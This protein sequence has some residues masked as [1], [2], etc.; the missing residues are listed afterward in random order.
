MSGPEANGSAA[1]KIRRRCSQRQVTLS[2]WLC[3]S[4]F[5]VSMGV[6]IWQFVVLDFDRMMIAI[7][8]ALLASQLG[9]A[10]EKWLYEGEQFSYSEY[11]G[12]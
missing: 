8:I 1:R 10:I 12:R 7:V 9:L 4:L 5:I 3:Y 6:V 11:L 2:L